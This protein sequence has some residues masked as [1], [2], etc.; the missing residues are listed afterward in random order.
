MGISLFVP[1]LAASI[2]SYATRLL[3][4]SGGA[5]LWAPVLGILVVIGLA[6]YVVSHFGNRSSQPRARRSDD[7][8]V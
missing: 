8:R 7:G 2:G 4:A 3:Q 6:A 1:S 5:G